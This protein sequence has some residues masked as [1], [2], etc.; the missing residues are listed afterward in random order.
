MVRGSW[1]EIDSK[2]QTI[3]EAGYAVRGTRKEINSKCEATLEA[4]YAVRGTWKE[5]NSKCE[6]TLEAALKRLLSILFPADLVVR[7]C[8]RL[9]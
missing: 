1:N 3:L 4:G 5:I 9:R 8:L 2:S 6:A 7:Y